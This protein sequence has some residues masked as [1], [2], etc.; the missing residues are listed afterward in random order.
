VLAALLLSWRTIYDATYRELL[1]PDDLVA[2]LP[3]R[4]LGDV[5]WLVV[6]VLATWI[7][8]DAAGAVGVRRLVLERRPVLAAWL[9]GYADLVRRVHRVVPTALVGIGA[10]V[11]LAGP[12]LLAAAAGWARVR[13]VLLDG[14]DP[15]TVL[16]AIAIWVA[17]WLGALVLAGVAAAF[18]VASWTFELPRP[19]E[20]RRD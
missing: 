13:E 20:A 12:G 10:V 8:A 14:R 4:V 17:V 18:R 2:P 5:P 9:L 6:G 19:G 11:L 7:L 1:F 16:G 3:I 15:L